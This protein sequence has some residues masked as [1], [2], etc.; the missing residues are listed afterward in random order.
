[1]TSSDSPKINRQW[2]LTSRPQGLVTQDNFDWIEESLSSLENGAVRI[3]NIYLSLDPAQRGWMNEARGYRRPI[4][5]GEVITSMGIGVV[6]QSNHSDFAVGDFVTGLLG[7]QDY[8]TISGKHLLGLSNVPGDT[9]FSLAEFLGPLGTNGL[10]AYFGLL[11]VGNPK[12]GET[13]VVSAAAGATGSLVGQIGK[14]KGCRVVGI[15]GSDEKCRRLVDE[16]GFDAAVNY[17]TESVYKRL[18]ELCPDGIDVYLKMW[19]GKSS[20]RSCR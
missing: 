11:D 5:I 9:G 14:I 3:R 20:K 17:K 4:E 15:A 16:L 8:A 10:T 12:S 13:L 2:R 1:M 6:V 7:W 18:K 19:A